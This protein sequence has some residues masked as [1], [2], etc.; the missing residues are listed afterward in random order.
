MGLKYNIYLDGKFIKETTS[1]STIVDGLEVET[2]YS[3]SVS[4]T[5]GE[6]ESKQTSPIKFK[7]LPNPNLLPNTDFI[8]GMGNWI[9]YPNA[10]SFEILNAESDKP[11]SKIIH[12]Q[13]VSQTNQQCYL[14]PHNILVYPG[15]EYTVSFDYKDSNWSKTTTV[16][17]IRITKTADDNSALEYFPV[18]VTEAV[19]NWK[20]LKTTFTVTTAGFLSFNFYDN[21]S[22]G[23]HEGFFREAKVEEGN[24]AT[25]WIPAE[26]D[27]S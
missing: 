13:A 10:S 9:S 6:K 7:T 26:S 8:N 19:P 4:E 2:E 25:S 14:K 23:N 27:L 12:A 21:D 11:N 24:T 20:R 16:A 17:Q 18:N 5:D 1:L 15:E 22:T 3:V